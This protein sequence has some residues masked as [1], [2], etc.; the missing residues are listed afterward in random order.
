MAKSRLYNFFCCVSN[1]E[2]EN[3]YHK[4]NDTEELKKHV[5]ELQARMKSIV[6]M[7]DK[8]SNVH[9]LLNGGGIHPLSFNK[10]LEA[11]KTETN[12]L[13][14]EAADAKVKALAMLQE[15]SQ[16]GGNNLELITEKANELCVVL[17]YQSI[18]STAA[19]AVNRMK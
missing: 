11:I 12:K 4:L 16:L 8:N 14:I 7:K 1:V 19:P 10:L 2:D 5:E 18:S 9:G 17:G 15:L 3:A 6:E 13:P